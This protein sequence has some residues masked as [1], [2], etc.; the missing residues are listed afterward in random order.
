MGEKEIGGAA[1]QRR[2]HEDFYELFVCE[3]DIYEG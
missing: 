3:M 1:G 2:M